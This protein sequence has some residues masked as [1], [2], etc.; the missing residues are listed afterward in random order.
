MH[1]HEKPN[2]LALEN[3]PRNAALQNSAVNPEDVITVP[4]ATPKGACYIRFAHYEYNDRNTPS[5]TSKSK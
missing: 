2:W 4:L 5:L 3:S 1:L